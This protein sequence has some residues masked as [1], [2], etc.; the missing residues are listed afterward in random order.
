MT[1]RT[2]FKLV[3]ATGFFLLASASASARSATG[4][5]P[6]PLTNV[7]SSKGIAAQLSQTDFAMKPTLRRLPVE[8]IDNMNLE[9]II[10]EDFSK[11]TDGSEDEIDGAHLTER[12]FVGDPFIDPEFTD[13]PG[14]S[15]LGVYQAGGMCALAYPGQGGVLNSPT[16]DLSGRIV[17]K[18]RAK[19]YA[20]SA[21]MMVHLCKGDLQNPSIATPDYDYVS[22]NLTSDEWTEVVYELKNPDSSLPSFVQFNGMSYNQ[23]ILLDD[24]EIFR[25]LDYIFSPADIAAKNFTT[26]G[27]TLDWSAVPN[28]DGYS[29]NL[30]E[31]T[32][33]SKENR[34]AEEDF[35]AIDLSTSEFS[36]S[37]TPK[38]W[39][40]ELSGD[41]QV[42]AKGGSGGSP[43]IVFSKDGDFIELP[44]IDGKYIDFSFDI[45]PIDMA[46]G[47]MPYV[48]IMVLNEGEW[49]MWA[50]F[51]PNPDYTTLTVSAAA[52]EAQ[53]PAWYK[54]NML[55][56]GIRL[57][58]A[59][60]GNTTNKLAIDNISFT[61]TPLTEKR[62]IE[63][64][65]MTDT[66]SITFTGLDPE[67]EHFA[68][69][70][71][72]K[73]DITSDNPVYF[74][75]FGVATPQ[76]LPAT[77]IDLRGAFTANW[78]ATPKADTY[79][80]EVCEMTTVREDTKE[81]VVF[82]DN[83]N[84][85]HSSGVVGTPEP[86]ENQGEVSLD[87]YTD[88]K[89]WIGSHA[90]IAEGMIG[91]CEN[92]YELAAVL[93]PEITLSNNGGNYTV[94]V[95]AFG[96]PGDMLVVQGNDVYQIIPFD[97]EG[98]IEE[99][100][101]LT[102]GLHND[103][104]FIYT[105]MGGYFLLDYIKITQNLLEGDELYLK[106]SETEVKG[107]TNARI[108]LYPEENISYCYMVTA[109]HN[110]LDLSCQSEPSDAQIIDFF[111]Y[112]DSVEAR[113]SMVSAVKGLLVINLTDNE[114]VAI[115]DIS[116]RKVR[117]FTATQGITRINLPGGIYVTVI[118]G[119]S[120]K[121][122][123]K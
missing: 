39:Q 34:T 16:G 100:V 105:Y 75:A 57:I 59:D 20:S 12:Y 80:V 56:S 95:K 109:I 6:T 96:T 81:Y 49:Q 69:V 68:E 41:M 60:F 88:K 4:A 123:V 43:A 9:L 82:E 2:T 28:V 14:W 27:F 47:T 46:E 90:C 98:L 40:I 91:G 29:V 86:L 21:F 61:A 3:A 22:L 112:V 66:N 67:A 23:G 115:F 71:S 19:A 45:T 8:N 31:V 118:G 62:Q 94:E 52:Q 33:P 5:M 97:S 119:K 92:M 7:D 116:G 73:G 72:V 15:G 108:S 104:I 55:Y 48:Q 74:H 17:I 13:Q 38:D 53:D 87:G 36:T 10:K 102:N 103:R 64:M 78:E 99:S 110:Y 84:R 107:E 44:V 51:D 76:V 101:D 85:C 58:A 89:G 121:S 114:D 18:F 54:F 50:G 83:F 120:F 32:M 106:L 30:Y 63:N 35:N 65:L 113:S 117:Q 111:T 77:D 42:T 25:D 70:M 79:I 24:I 122:F 37:D 93:S 1:N 26:D 11:F